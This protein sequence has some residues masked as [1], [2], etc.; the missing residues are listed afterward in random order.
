MME[1]D[2]TERELERKTVFHGIIIDV[3]QDTVELPDGTS[4]VREVVQHPGGV[5]IVAVDERMNALMVRQYRYAMGREML[6]VPAGKLELGEDPA[7]AA[8]REL[9]EE[10]GC[11]CSGFEAL[12]RVAA[13]PGV[14]SETLWLY[15]A[16]G[17]EYVG[18]QPDE[19]EFLKIE[20]I[21]LSEL[22]KRCLS[23]EIEDAKTNIAVLRA[24][25]HLGVE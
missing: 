7:Q 6:E 9:R 16:T 8:R 20:R 1:L 10:T 3:R 23:G 19:G 22:R 5:S 25:A 4:A 13:S 15:L 11:V 12:G 24:C 17:L 21:P 14:Y 2:L 18:E